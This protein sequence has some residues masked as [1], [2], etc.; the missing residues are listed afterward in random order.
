MIK[1]IYP[2][3]VVPYIL[4]RDRISETPTVFH[5]KPLTF[6]ESQLVTSNIKYSL[7]G[8]VT[9]QN[10]AEVKEKIFGMKVVKVE[11]WPTSEG[12]AQT[13]TDPEE[14]KALFRCL[15]VADGLEIVRAI[16]NRSTLEEGDIKNLDYWLSLE[17]TSGSAGIPAPSTAPVAGAATIGA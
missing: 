10:D 17:N 16:Q 4:R 15:E 1:P 2:E 8:E 13:V 9:I 7:S 14:I 12:H 6:Y 3:Q 11:N 5:I